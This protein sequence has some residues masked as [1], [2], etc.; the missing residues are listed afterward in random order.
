[1]V[2]EEVEGDIIMDVNKTL[3]YLGECLSCESRILSLEKMKERLENIQWNISRDNEEYEM[4]LNGK[5][6]KSSSLY[7]PEYKLEILP[8]KLRDVYNDIF[9]D[10][11]PFYKDSYKRDKRYFNMHKKAYY[12]DSDALAFRWELGM[13]L[14]VRKSLKFLSGN[15]LISNDYAI[16]P[17]NPHDKEIKS[18]F[19]LENPSDY[20]HGVRRLRLVTGD[21]VVCQVLNKDEEK[22]NNFLNGVCD[23]Y[24]KYAED[25]FGKKYNEYIISESII[26]QK[27]KEILIEI[28]KTKDV[29]KDL[30]N[31]NIINKK[32]QNIIAISSFID[33]LD[34]G[35]CDSFDGAYGCYNLFESESKQDE[36][37][38]KLG[39]IVNL[40]E[41]IKKQQYALYCVL[42][43]IDQRVEKIN[44]S[45]QEFRK[46]YENN[47]RTI[48]NNLNSLND[49]TAAIAF[50]TSLSNHLL[51]ISKEN[52]EAIIHNQEFEQLVYTKPSIFGM[53][54]I[55]AKALSKYR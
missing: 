43:E 23:F 24:K 50:E 34:S 51:E 8:K 25:V 7:V 54:Q 42:K 6:L 16:A 26:N 10:V 49:N 13:R 44:T 55:T 33:Y 15:T 2:N 47:Y 38:T 41:D 1:M 46:N 17:I 4:I 39:K 48:I 19:P 36:I 20:F 3:E 30:Y 35:R 14:L 53:R 37:I 29:L 21:S 52:Q 27:I 45:F 5:I 22:I 32:Y 9:N 18:L 31:L 40:L 12:S 28:D 11:K